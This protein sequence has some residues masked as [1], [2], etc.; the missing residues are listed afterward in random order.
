MGLR[1]WATMSADCKPKGEASSTETDSWRQ[2]RWKM[3]DYQPAETPTKRQVRIRRVPSSAPTRALSPQDS[4]PR[5]Q[6]GKCTL[7]HISVQSDMQ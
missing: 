4:V 2:S 3:G 1:P 7:S 5:Y 6:P